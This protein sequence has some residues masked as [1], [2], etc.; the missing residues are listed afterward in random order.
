MDSFGLLAEVVFFGMGVYF[1]L[2]S[3]GK[4]KI[5]KAE[6]KERIDAFFEGKTLFLRILAVFLVVVMGLNL[7]VHIAQLFG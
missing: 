2:L 6:D 1:L 3:F 7:I 5:K 4:I